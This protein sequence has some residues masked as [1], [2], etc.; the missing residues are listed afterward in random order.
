MR[1]LSPDRSHIA[2]SAGDVPG[3]APLLADEGWA[4]ASSLP[5][6]AGGPGRYQALFGRDSLIT[7]LQVLPARPE[8]ARSTLHALAARQGRARDPAT[9]EAPG[10]IGHEFR[11]Q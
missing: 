2:D 7:S 3:L 11:D 1:M 4:Y 5:T 9:L 8:V 10:K 6:A